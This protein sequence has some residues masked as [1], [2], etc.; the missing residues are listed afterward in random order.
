MAVDLPQRRL[1]RVDHLHVE[2]E[3]RSMVRGHTT[4]KGLDE[5]IVF[6]SCRALGQLGE[7]LGVRLTVDDRFEHG[8]TA[9]ADDARKDAVELDVSVLQDLLNSHRVLRHLADELFARP[10][11]VAQLLNRSRRYEAA[12]DQPVSE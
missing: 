2:L 10:R 3:H 8:A 1:D 7:P 5:R 4:P 11:Q 12:A 6:L 9:L